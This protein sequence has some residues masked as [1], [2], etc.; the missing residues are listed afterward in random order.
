MSLNNESDEEIVSNILNL[1]GEIIDHITSYIDYLSPWLNTSNSVRNIVQPTGQLERFLELPSEIQNLILDQLS[2]KDIGN[3]LSTSKIVSTSL[4]RNLNRNPKIDHYMKFYNLDREINHLIRQNRSQEA[5]QLYKNFIIENYRL[6]KK[7]EEFFGKIKQLGKL[8]QLRTRNRMEMMPFR[9]LKHKNPTTIITRIETPEYLS[10]IS[11]NK[12]LDDI[13]SSIFDLDL[14]NQ[15]NL[16][17][18]IE[19]LNMYDE[20]L[21][22]SGLNNKRFIQQILDRY[23]L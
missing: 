22:T 12:F 23:Y 7:E 1:P 2:Y 20:E 17:K 15:N 18:L 4:R 14:L 8:L 3:L 6:I 9:E 16:R 10:S 13:V 19:L 5:T 21:N 11:Q